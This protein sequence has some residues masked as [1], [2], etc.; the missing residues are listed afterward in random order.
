MTMTSDQQYMETNNEG[1]LRKTVIIIISGWIRMNQLAAC[2]QLQ[3]CSLVQLCCDHYKASIWV[4]FKISNNLV[5]KYD[6]R[7]S[8]RSSTAENRPSMKKS[9]LAEQQYLRCECSR[10]KNS[11]P[12]EWIEREGVVTPIQQRLF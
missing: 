5:H 7:G 2:F 6:P 8:Y 9:Y 12:G 3:L 10:T 4:Y 11:E 1:E